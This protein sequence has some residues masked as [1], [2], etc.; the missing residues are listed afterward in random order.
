MTLFEIIF[1]IFFW[2]IHLG[3]PLVAIQLNGAMHGL[4]GIVS[5]GDMLTGAQGFA[6][7]AYYFGWIKSTTGITTCVQ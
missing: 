4:V 2:S 6:R 3:G 5:F 1:S 7:I